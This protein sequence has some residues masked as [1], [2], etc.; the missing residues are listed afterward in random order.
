MNTSDFTKAQGH[1]ILAR[2]GKKVLRPGGKQLTRQLIEALNI[3][4]ENDLVE[5]APGLGFTAALALKENPRSYIGIDAQEDAVELLNRKNKQG[6]ASFILG[7]AAETGLHSESKDRVF[8]EAML[9]MHADHR[10]TEIIQEAH[11]ILKK[12]GLYAIHELGLFPEELAEEVKAGIQRDLA[13]AIKVNAR[14]LTVK[15]WTHLVESE[16]FRV[17]KVVTRSMRLLEPSRII[18][19]EGFW[20]TLKIGFNIIRHPEARRRI[21]RMRATFKKHRQHINAIM[22]V[23]EKL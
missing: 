22:M 2:M 17:R 5:F 8:G 4:P 7:N 10:K 21:F 14:P 1:W 23:A 3:S 9:T 15:E 18:D 19:D 11:R 16:G 20:R 13:M 6:N 12:G